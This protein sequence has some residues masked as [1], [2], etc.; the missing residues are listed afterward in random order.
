MSS[1]K[2]ERQS[3]IKGLDRFVN[4]DRSTKNN[5]ISQTTYLFFAKMMHFLMKNVFFSKQTRVT[6]GV[7]L[8]VRR[9][10]AS[11]SSPKSRRRRFS[12]LST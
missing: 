10:Y 5:L 6:Q 2:F 7:N 4:T 3:F 11:Y 12:S 9:Q 1:E 8:P